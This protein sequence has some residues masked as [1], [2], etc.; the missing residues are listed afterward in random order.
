MTKLKPVFTYAILKT[1][2]KISNFKIPIN[3]ANRIC[4]QDFKKAWIKASYQSYVASA[5]FPLKK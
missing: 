1:S 4:L 5:K 2:P 3:T